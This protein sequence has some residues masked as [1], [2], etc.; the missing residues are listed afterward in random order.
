MSE[1]TIYH[2]PRC[3]KS[4]QTLALLEAQGI[5]PTVVLYLEN[6]PDAGAL[7]QILALLEL[8][9]RALMRSKEPEYE[10]LDLANPAHS[11]DALIAAMVTDPILIERPIVIAGARAAIGRPPE[12]VLEIL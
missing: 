3:S 4:R 6:P 10:A 1:V 11:D 12:K 9:P 2:N 8:T 5:N 7:K